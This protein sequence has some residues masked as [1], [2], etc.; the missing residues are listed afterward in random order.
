ML[1]QHLLHLL[2]RLLDELLLISKE[3]AMDAFLLAAASRPRDNRDSSSW[4]D[5]DVCHTIDYCQAQVKYFQRLPPTFRP[6]NHLIFL[7]G[8]SS[9]KG[10]FRH[11]TFARWKLPVGQNRPFCPSAAEKTAFRWAKSAL[12]PIR[13]PRKPPGVPQKPPFWCPGP[14]KTARRPRSPLPSD[15]AAEII[16]GYCEKSSI[17]T[18]R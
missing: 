5:I 18:L 13:D 2:V 9:G 6:Q 8:T 17:F 15:K 16:V 14:A 7:A 3:F 11:P 12:L 4:G 1:R 10:E